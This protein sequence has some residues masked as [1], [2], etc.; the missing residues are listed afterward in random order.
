MEKRIMKPS[1]LRNEIKPS[2][3]PILKRYTKGHIKNKSEPSKEIPEW[4]F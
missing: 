3:V 4:D 1:P 2:D